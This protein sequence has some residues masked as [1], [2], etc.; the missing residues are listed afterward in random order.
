MIIPEIDLTQYPPETDQPTQQRLIAE[1]ERWGLFGQCAL[2]NLQLDQVDAMVAV[3]QQT[4]GGVDLHLE[5][6]AGSDSWESAGL[7]LLNAGATSLICGVDRIDQ[8]DTIPTD[9]LR[10]LFDDDGSDQAIPANH[11][12]VSPDPTAEKVAELEMARIDVLVPSGLLDENVDLMVQFFQSVLV[13]DRPDGLW[14]TVIVDPLGV[15]LGLAFS[16]ADSLTYALENRVGAYHSRSRDE[17]WVKGESSGATQRLLGVR[18]DCDRDCLQFRVTQSPP[19]FCH[20]NTYTCFGSQRSINSVVERLRERIS[21][22]DEKS[23]TRKLARDAELLKTKLLEE[24]GEL[25]QASDQLSSEEV[26]WE[27]A[28]VLFFSLVAMLKRGVTLDAVYA[29]LARRMNRVVRR[30]NKL[31]SETQS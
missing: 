10:H 9:R 31:D 21:E 29:E 16:N 17:L 15:A 30:P 26:T 4:A 3:L 25:A 22:T 12:V 13:T 7:E 6:N 1:I 18:M 5:L 11:V 2:R 19:G 14:A 20:R 24:A 28:D 8:L 23:F 27:A